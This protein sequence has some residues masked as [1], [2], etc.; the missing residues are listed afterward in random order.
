[1][2]RGFLYIVWGDSVE[3]ALQRSLASLRAFH[4]EL[5]VE[6]IR[7]PAADSMLGL[8]AKTTM[9]ARTPFAETLFLDADTVVLD[10]LDAGFEAAARHGLACCICEN[11]WAARYNGL[12]SRPDLIEYNTGVLFFTAKAKPVF[13]AWPRLSRDIDSSMFFLRDGRQKRMPYNDQCGFAA[14]VAEA[15]IS[16]FV[17]PLNWNF[18]P[19][20]MDAFFGP[21]K[22]WHGY[23]Q[24]PEELAALNARYRSGEMPVIQRHSIARA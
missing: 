18:R 21:L 3:P 16:P 7:L 22:I 6:V 9:A 12:K 13:D 24:V 5:P 10:R 17:L 15:G 19:E 8:A 1:M 20:F 2:T 23:E 14:A 4:P 11:P